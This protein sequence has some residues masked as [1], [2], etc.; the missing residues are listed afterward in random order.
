M[1][2][3]SD[4][5]MVI[6]LQRHFSQLN[7]NMSYLQVEMTLADDICTWATARREKGK[8]QVTKGKLQLKEQN[9]LFY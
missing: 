3:H 6:V 9:E 1:I 7:P 5:G 8:D 2:Q 4:F